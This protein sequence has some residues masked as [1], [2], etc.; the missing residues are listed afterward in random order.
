MHSAESPIGTTTICAEVDS[1][2]LAYLPEIGKILIDSSVLHTESCHTPTS[3]TYAPKA[4]SCRIPLPLTLVVQYT[5]Y[6]RLHLHGYQ[7][8]LIGVTGRCQPVS[9][10]SVG[11]HRKV[12][13][14]TG[15][16]PAVWSPQ[17]H[18]CC[19]LIRLLLGK[20]HIGIH[21]PALCTTHMSVRAFRRMSYTKPAVMSYV[22]YP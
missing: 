19:S 9:V 1:R 4:S 22:S 12:T 8:L 17:Q 18:I 5:C 11:H 20:S 15:C 6:R 13:G 2:L 14:L 16:W 10:K 3:A 7:H 21:G